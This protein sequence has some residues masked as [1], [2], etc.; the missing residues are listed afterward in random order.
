VDGR[1]QLFCLSNILC[2]GAQM[3]RQVPLG[4]WWVKAVDVLSY[5]FCKRCY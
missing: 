5:L 3:S 1:Y 2:D 4:F